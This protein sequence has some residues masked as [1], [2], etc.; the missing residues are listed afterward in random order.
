MGIFSIMAGPMLFTAPAGVI[1]QPLS[2]VITLA[3]G[4]CRSRLADAETHET[5]LRLVRWLMEKLDASSLHINFLPEDEW[6]LFGDG[7][8][9]PH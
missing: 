1:T 7:A 2:V 9:A 5:N 8:I 6:R 4:R 3:G